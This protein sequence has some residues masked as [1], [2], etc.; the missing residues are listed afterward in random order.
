[1]VATEGGLSFRVPE[2]DL[3]SVK[4][5][6]AGDTIFPQTSDTLGTLR[7][8]KFQLFES[9]KDSGAVN[10]VRCPFTDALKRA[11]D[12]CEDT[13]GARTVAEKELSS[14]VCAL[15]Q[16]DPPAKMTE[17]PTKGTEP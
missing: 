11:A 14:A 7:L 6:E 1:M 3:A 8:A 4:T 5:W 16:S 17:P 12:E 10:L 15:E 13:S 9:T 2:A